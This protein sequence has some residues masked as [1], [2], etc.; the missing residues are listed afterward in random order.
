MPGGRLRLDRAQLAQPRHRPAV[1]F[2]LG[3]ALLAVEQLHPRLDLFQHLARL[4][5]PALFEQQRG[6]ATAPFLARQACDEIGIELERLV[7]APQRIENAR[8]E[9]ADPVA[10][11]L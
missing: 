6:I 3:S 2:R 7:L 1:H 9:Q 5:V 4:L 11:A 10:V 8:A